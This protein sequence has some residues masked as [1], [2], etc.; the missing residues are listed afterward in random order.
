MKRVQRKHIPNYLRKYRKLAGY[1]QSEVALLLGLKSTSMIS[2]WET[3]VS[4]PDT[5]N[6]LWLAVLYGT[7]MDALFHNL[8]EE[9]K[10]ELATRKEELLGARDSPSVR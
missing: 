4:M 9:R 8:R 10:F 3:G 6:L 2:R 5:D 7:M 1:K